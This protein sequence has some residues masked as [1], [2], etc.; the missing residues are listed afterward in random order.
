MLKEDHW[1]FAPLIAYGLVDRPNDPDISSS[2]AFPSFPT[3]RY[4]GIVSAPLKTA[5]FEPDVVI[6]L[7]R[8]PAQLRIMLLPIH[9][10]SQESEI[11]YHL[12][13]RRAP[14]SSCARWR[15]GST[16][17]AFRLRRLRACPCIERRNHTLRS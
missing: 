8:S 15:P 2:T 10:T 5:P 4:I 9:F 1:C 7:L 13:P 14:T 17:S 3:G 6:V 11:D 12:F 16:W